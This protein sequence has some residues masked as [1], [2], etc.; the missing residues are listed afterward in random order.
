MVPLSQIVNRMGIYKDLDIPQ[1]EK[2]LNKPILTGIPDDWPTVRDAIDLGEPLLKAAPRSKVRQ[3]IEAL[4]NW[5]HTGKPVDFQPETRKGGALA[6][7]F[8]KG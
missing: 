6:R 7:L 3:A 5:V 1:A 4:A 2:T 8:G